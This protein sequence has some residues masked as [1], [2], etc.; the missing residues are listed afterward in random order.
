MKPQPLLTSQFSAPIFT[1]SARAGTPNAAAVRTAA[2]APIATRDNLVMV[3]I[4]R[5]FASQ[6]EPKK[7]A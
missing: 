5:S 1:P 2:A 3:E 7:T 4:P 6:T